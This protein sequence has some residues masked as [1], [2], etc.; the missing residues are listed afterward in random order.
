MAGIDFRM[1]NIGIYTEL[2]YLSSTTEDS[3]GAKTKIGGNGKNLG[4]GVSFGF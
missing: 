1:K 2:K 4:L 3:A